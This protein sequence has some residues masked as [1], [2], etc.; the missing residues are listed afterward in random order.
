MSQS[1]FTFNVKWKEELVVTGP[2][3][4]QFTLEL[5]MGIL[6]AYLPAEFNWSQKAPYWAIDLWPTLKHDLEAWC[7]ENNAKLVI[8]ASAWVDFT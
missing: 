1:V 8:D 2:S 5:T 3:G 4:R 7:A 6:T